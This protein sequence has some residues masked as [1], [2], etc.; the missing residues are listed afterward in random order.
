MRCNRPSFNIIVVGMI[1]NVPFVER[2]VDLLFRV[3]FALYGVANANDCFYKFVHCHTFG[4]E[5]VGVARLI[6]VVLMERN[7][8]NLVICKVKGLKLPIAEGFHTEV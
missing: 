6:V 7:V 3:L 5:A 8:I 2:E 4:K 1:P